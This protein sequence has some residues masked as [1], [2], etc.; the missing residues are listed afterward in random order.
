MLSLEQFDH[1]YIY[2]PS[3]D[4]RKG[5]QGLSVFVQEELKLNP[6]ANYLFLFCNRRKIES[7]HCIGIKQ[8]LLFGINV[9]KRNNINGHVI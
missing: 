6:F 3:I 4:F 5:V 1:I 7:K 2:R 8:G 9:W